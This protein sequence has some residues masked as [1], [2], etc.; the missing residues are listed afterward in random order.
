MMNV[1]VI[2][3]NADK[4]AVADHITR[5]KRASYAF[6]PLVLENGN[7]FWKIDAA[8][9]IKRSQMVIFVVGEKSHGSKWIGWEIKTAIRYGKPIYT[10]FL[11]ANNQPHAELFVKDKF[12]DTTYRYDTEASVDSIAEIISKHEHGDYHI[13]NQDFDSMDKA[14]LFEQYKLFLKTSEDLVARRQ[15]VNSFYISVNSALVALFAAG[16]ALS[17]D[18]YYKI[19]L[20]AIFVMVGLVLSASWIKT[21]TS[22]GNLNASKMTIIRSIERQLPASLYD[23]EWQ[24]LSDKLNKSKYISFTQNEARIPMIFIGIY[25]AVAVVLVAI[26]AIALFA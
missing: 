12:T 17:I 2:H 4:A 16:M 7:L 22:Y 5:I 15:N 25:S 23:A 24:A 19:A 8:K 18:L 14:M 11:D 13:F 1:F 10:V 3:S 26:L 21:L 6:N 9:K 20:G